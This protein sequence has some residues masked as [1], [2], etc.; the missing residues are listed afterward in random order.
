MCQDLQ[1]ELHVILFFVGV[2]TTAQS[3]ILAGRCKSVF[4]QILQ[5][6]VEDVI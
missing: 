5:V 3:M 2:V 4:M 1:T 6:L